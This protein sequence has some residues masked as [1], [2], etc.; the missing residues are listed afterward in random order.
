MKLESWHLNRAVSRKEKRP[1]K[2][3]HYHWNRQRWLRFVGK[4][5]QKIKGHIKFFNRMYSLAKYND[6]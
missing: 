2:T 3:Q 1:T 6:I 5:Y 4:P